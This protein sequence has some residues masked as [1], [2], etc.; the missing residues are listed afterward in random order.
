MEALELK[1]H[2]KAWHIV[3][4]QEM[5]SPPFLSLSLLGLWLWEVRGSG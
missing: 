1:G 2:C 5:G 4:A 3:G